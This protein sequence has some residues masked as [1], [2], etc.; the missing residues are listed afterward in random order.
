[1]RW[2]RRRNRCV[3]PS[4]AVGV[5]HV[6]A[7]RGLDRERRLPLRWSE[8][9][10]REPVFDVGRRRAGEGKRPGVRGYW[11]ARWTETE[12]DLSSDFYWKAV[13]RTHLGDPEAALKWLSKSYETHELESGF[14]TPLINLLFNHWWDGLHDDPRFAALLDKIGYTKVMPSRKR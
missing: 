2:T 3:R 9:P 11:Q 4:P 5:D 7:L 8:L 13:V 6:N 10:A 12:K 14:Q 1:M